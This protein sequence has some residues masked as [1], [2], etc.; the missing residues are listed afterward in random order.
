[1]REAPAV[2]GL[3]ASAVKPSLRLTH[4]R[5]SPPR[6]PRV[7]FTARFLTARPSLVFGC[8]RSET[9]AWNMRSRSCRAWLLGGRGSVSLYLLIERGKERVEWKEQ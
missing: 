7:P 3:P 2:L 4:L 8:L 9:H 6:L 1:M 5:E